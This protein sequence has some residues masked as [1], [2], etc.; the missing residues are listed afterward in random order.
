VTV[1]AG[2]TVYA[3]GRRYQIAPQAIIA[4]NKLRAP[5]HLEVGQRLRLP[6]AASAETAAPA[7]R[8]VARDTLYEVRNSDTLL[9]VARAHGVEH[10]TIAQANNLVAPYPLAPGQQLLSPQARVDGS[11]APRTAAAPAPAQ[12]LEASRQEPKN[13]GELAQAVSYTPPPAPA[14]QPPASRLFEWPVKGAIIAKFGAGELGR[15]ND[16]VNIAAPMGTPVRA[17][18]DGE[19][20]YRGSELD[21]FGNLLLVKHTD[22]YVTAYAH[23]DS[24]LV[25]K[26]QQVRQGQVIAKVGQTGSVSAPQLHF[27]IRQ[28]LKSVDP[29]VLLGPQ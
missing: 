10:I 5:Y 8:V 1:Q 7:R 25:Q 6:A 17:A 29:A 21:G 3:L 20:V 23:N 14:A 15:R 22:G 9:S 27:E 12:P 24:M 2:D 16:G 28:D 4:E 11:A 18:A 19:V 26:G 13:V